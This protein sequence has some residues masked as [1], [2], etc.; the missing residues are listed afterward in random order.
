MFSF[1]PNKL[2]QIYVICSVRRKTY[3]TKY[4]LCGNTFVNYCSFFNDL[5][6]L[7]DGMFCTSFGFYQIVE[8][9]MNMTECGY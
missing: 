5:E 4:T 3:Y 9:A 7:L 1:Q 2:G 6:S 8:V